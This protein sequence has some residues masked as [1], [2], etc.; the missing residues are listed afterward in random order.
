MQPRKAREVAIGRAE[1]QTVFNGYCGEV[2]IRHEVR[3]NAGRFKKVTK[4][5]T[6]AILGLRYPDGIAAKPREYLPPCVRYARG[7]IEHTWIGGHA[8][9]CE[10]ARPWQS[11]RCRAV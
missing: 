6:M 10:E 7:T 4:N 3:V 1:D 9:K 2:R 8:Q 11:D 5:F